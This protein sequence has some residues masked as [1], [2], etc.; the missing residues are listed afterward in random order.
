MP[1]QIY[2][3][4]KVVEPGPNGYTIYARIPEGG[5]ELCELDGKTYITIPSDAEL[6][7]QHEAITLEPVIVDSGLRERIKKASRAVLLIDQAVIDLIRSQ[8]SVDDE[9]YF[10][11]IGVGVAL[12]AYQFEDGEQE[13]MLAFGAHVEAC[14]QWGRAQRAA[15]GL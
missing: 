9:A 12:G 8:Y 1:A 5:L 7:E 2:R 15:L 3:Y 6:L 4:T 10:A 11:R 14:R 13:A